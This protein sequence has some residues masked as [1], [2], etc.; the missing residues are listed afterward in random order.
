[1][2]FTDNTQKLLNTIKPDIVIN[3][4]GITIRRGININKENTKLLNSDLP[5]LFNNWVEKNKKK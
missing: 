3:C 2:I 4:V 1:M 5:H